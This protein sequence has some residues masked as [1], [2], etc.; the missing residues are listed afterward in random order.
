MILLVKAFWGGFYNKGN[1][2]KLS[3]ARNAGIWELSSIKAYKRN[4][5]G[6][7]SILY[8]SYVRLIREQYMQL[9]RHR[10]YT[11]YTK[12]A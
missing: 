1:F 11:R 10:H 7:E 9:F 4:I 3:H 12:R 5:I 6:F 8:Y 2:E